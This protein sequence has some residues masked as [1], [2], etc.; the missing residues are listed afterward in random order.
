[1]ETGKAERGLLVKRRPL[2][3]MVAGV[4]A[5]ARVAGAVEGMVSRV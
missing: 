3:D 2:E 5:V 4:V 1:M